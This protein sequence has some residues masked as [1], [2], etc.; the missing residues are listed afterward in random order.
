M[1]PFSFFFA[2]LYGLWKVFVAAFVGRSQQRLYVFEANLWLGCLRSKAA[3]GDLWYSGE[4][5]KAWKVLSV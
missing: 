3:G 5:D 2:W 1:V 4:R